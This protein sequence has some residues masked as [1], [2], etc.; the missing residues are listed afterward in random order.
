[1]PNQ[2]IRSVKELPEWYDLN[3]YKYASTL[4]AADWYEL[5]LQRWNHYFYIEDNSESYSDPEDPFYQA[6][7]QLRKSPLSKLTDDMHITLIGSKLSALK[8]DKEYFS[9]SSN[10][11]KPLTFRRLY[12]NENRLNRTTLTRVRKWFDGIF[13]RS[14]RNKGLSEEFKDESKW[15]KSFIDD[16]LFDALQKQGKDENVE[17][18]NSWHYCDFVEIDLSIPD[19]ILLQQFSDYLRYVR[20]KYPFT[21]KESKYKYPEFFKWVD[22]SILPYLDLI[23]WAM[24]NNCS[25]PNRVMADAIY[26]VDTEKGEEVV[27]KTTK[28][29]ADMVM[30]YDYV[31]FLSTIAAHEIMEKKS[32]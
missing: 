30:D 11:I 9:I 27:R 3:K 18:Y 10:A 16:P 20:Q 23:I 13:N 22:Y 19:K 6:L 4:N 14:Y 2:I 31:D 7:L 26:P 1:M 5:I 29:I 21:A 8:N 25:I 28:K 17:G 32:K 24:E 12:Q 15:A